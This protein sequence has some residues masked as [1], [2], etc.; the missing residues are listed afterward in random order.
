MSSKS[1]EKPIQSTKSFRAIP[2]TVPENLANIRIILF[3]PREPGNIGSVAR[4][5]K[6][7]GLSELYLVNPVPFQ[8]VDAAYNMAH[9]ARDLLKNCNVVPE[10]KDALEGIQYLVGT[11]HR[12]RDVR[13]PPPVTARDAA[14]KIASISQDKSVALL[15]GREDFGLSTDQI[16]LCQ[17]T[18]SVP[19][20]TKNPSLNL[21]QA[22]QIFV[23]EV[24]I[25]SLEDNPLDEI[26]YAEL[27]ALEDFYGRVT[28]LLDK[29]GMSPY[30]QEWETYLKSL[31]RVFSRAPL[32]ERDIAT[33]D[34][35]FSTAYRHIIRL[36]EKLGMKQEE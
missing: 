10:L 16:S 13:L 24:F 32:E 15:F 21:A 25:A 36:E 2:V 19:M 6:G 18:A 20:A 14:Q 34:M 26:E 33:L 12:R 28:R 3:E 8:N 1:Y 29:V 7:M 4:V 17:L 35:I 31:R 22:V 30:N 27:N 9:G 5:V 11:T 23:Y